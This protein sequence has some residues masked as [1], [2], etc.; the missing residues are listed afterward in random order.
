MRKKIYIGGD[1]FCAWRHNLYVH[2]PYILAKNLR[3]D[4]AGQGYPGHSWWKTYCDF[5]NHFEQFNKDTEIYI[6]CHT[7]PNRINCADT[8]TFIKNMTKN[9]EKY[10]NIFYDVDFHY[11]AMK[12]YYLQLNK[13]LIDK[14]VIHLFCFDNARDLYDV[15]SHG[16]YCDSLLIDMAN[17]DHTELG[18][19]MDGDTADD[20]P[21][22]NHFNK[23]TNKLIAS[24]LLEVCTNP[25]HSKNFTF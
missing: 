4:L 8:P 5:K 15:S 20:V 6:F 12:R 16:F 25:N 17:K 21:L 24:K 7:N 10:Y 11:W 9:A 13:L 19:T 1:S 22:Y 3:L 14:K 23:E 18:L 2:W